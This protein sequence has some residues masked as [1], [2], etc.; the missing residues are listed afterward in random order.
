MT[1]ASAATPASASS[2]SS[3][4]DGP[5]LRALARHQEVGQ[6][7]EQAQD[8]TQRRQRGQGPDQGRHP[9]R[10]HVGVLQGPGLGGGLGQRRRA[11]PARCPTPPARPTGP[12]ARRPRPPRSWQWTRWHTRTR[13]RTGLST[14]PRRA[15]SPTR[16][17]AWA[18]SVSSAL[19]PLPSSSRV[20][21]LVLPERALSMASAR[22]RPRWVNAVSATASTAENRSSTTDPARATISIVLT[23]AVFRDSGG[24]RPGSSTEPFQVGDLALARITAASSASAW[25]WP[26]TWRTPWTTSRATS[27]S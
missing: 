11:R 1:D 15:S 3:E 5:S 8:P 9:D 26:R 19:F 27:S 21:S 24:P 12:S 14:W 6:A 23:P 16:T 22:A 17:P 2:S 4:T 18:G 7:D 10:G 13:K 25:S 20:L